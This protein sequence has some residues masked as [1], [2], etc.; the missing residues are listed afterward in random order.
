MNN[1]LQASDMIQSLQTLISDLAYQV[2]YRDAIIKL[3]E[4]QIQELQSQVLYY[5]RKQE[6]AEMEVKI[7]D[8][9]VR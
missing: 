2:A 1:E 8:D 4:K 7:P 3:K 6:E 9:E 5:E